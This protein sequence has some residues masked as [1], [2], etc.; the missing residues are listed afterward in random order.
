MGAEG[1]CNIVFRNEITK[2]ENRENKRNELV[3]AYSTRFSNPYIAASKGYVDDV[4]EPKD[5]RQKLIS[6]L[7][8]IHKKRQNRPLRKHGNIPV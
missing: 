6:A 5:T 8:S 4:I 7:M 3:Q 1:A 2:S